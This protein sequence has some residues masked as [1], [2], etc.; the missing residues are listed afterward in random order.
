MKSGGYRVINLDEIVQIAEKNE[1]KL[2]FVLARQI[3]P[4]DIEQ[5]LTLGIFKRIIDK[6]A[7]N[8]NLNILQ[9][10]RDQFLYTHEKGIFVEPQ[11]IFGRKHYI[12]VKPKD[13]LMKYNGRISD[14]YLDVNEI[15]K[16][17]EKTGLE[18]M[19]ESLDYLIQK[20]ELSKIKE[21]EVIKQGINIIKFWGRV[22]LERILYMSKDI[23]GIKEDE[24]E[25]K[26]FRDNIELADGHEYEISGYEL[27]FEYKNAKLRSRVYDTSH[28][29]EN[30]IQRYGNKKNGY[31]VLALLSGS[32]RRY[33]L[34]EGNPEKE[35]QKIRNFYREAR[36]KTGYD[37][38]ILIVDEKSLIERG[39]IGKKDY[40]KF[41]GKDESKKLINI[42]KEVYGI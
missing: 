12:A 39:I 18:Y 31:I 29:H 7:F 28:I 13:E 32:K 35:D 5:R 37:I 15:E 36:E 1:G 38:P 4:F 42:I 16:M 21:G 11:T 33:I 17:I 24:Y 30:V 19:R 22:S 10:G 9:W 25:I 26:E 2:N 34:L 14:I 40:V 6:Y 8:I 3:A 20:G 23:F 41:I 27:A